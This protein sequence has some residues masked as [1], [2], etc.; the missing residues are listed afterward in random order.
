MLH[1]QFRR[2]AECF[3]EP[4]LLLSEQGQ[5]LAANPAGLALLGTEAQGL[6]G[7]LLP[8]YIS[9]D[10]QTAMRFLQAC[11]HSDTAVSATLCF[12]SSDSASCMECVGHLLADQEETPY[13]QRLLL[14]RCVADHKPPDPN[15]SA[16]E[17]LHHQRERLV[18]VGR[19]STMGEL[20]AGIA[21]EINQP[22]T[23][24]AAYAQAGRRLLAPTDTST[25]EL[26]DKINHQAQRAGQVIQRLRGMIRRRDSHRELCEVNRLVQETQVLTEADARLH[27]FHIRMCLADQPLPVVVDPIQIQQVVI[28]LIRNGLDAMLEAGIATGVLTIYTRR[29]DKDYAEIRVCDQGVGLPELLYNQLFTPFFTTKPQGI[30]LGLSISRSII[31]SHGGKLGFIPDNQRGATFYFTLPLA[32]DNGDD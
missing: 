21:H 19:L 7:S 9:G 12:T 16:A 18:H 32:L 29:L 3:S 31:V 1:T 13:G 25:A 22:L 11:V 24:I 15:S 14:V 30:G 27:H 26:L 28:N 17:A 20:A 8:D 4:L 10:Q 5:V 6:F 23:A 2:F